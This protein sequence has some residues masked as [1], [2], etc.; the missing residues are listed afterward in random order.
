[1]HLLHNFLSLALFALVG[2]Y[3]LSILNTIKNIVMAVCFLQL[4]LVISMGVTVLTVWITTYILSALFLAVLFCPSLNFT[5]EVPAYVGA[6]TAVYD[7]VVNYDPGTLMGFALGTCV[8]MGTVCIAAILC[9]AS[10]V[11]T[12]LQRN[13]S[14]LSELYPMKTSGPKH[15]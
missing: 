11:T 9:V 13:L 3:G 2:L 7:P 15:T 10:S 14:D 12:F 1:M 6:V 8:L 5:V 4:F